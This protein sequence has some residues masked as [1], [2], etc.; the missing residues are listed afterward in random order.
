MSMRRI[1]HNL[2]EVLAIL[3]VAALCVVVTLQVF[4]RL[5]LGAPLSWSEELATILFVWV[6]MVGASLALK[7]GEH[8]A[9]ELLQRQL[10]IRA[11][12]VVEILV[13]LILVGFAGLVF[14][15]G[16][17]MAARNMTVV[18]PAMEIPRAIPYG[19]VAGGGALMLLRSLELLLRSV[20][21]GHN[22]EGAVS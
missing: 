16:M 12:R 22:G 9:V 11:R 7:R 2:E 14:V 4:F 5:V 21:G 10:P 3:L 19:S 13:A 18:T 8:F 15:E 20:R 1:Y 17:G 6:T